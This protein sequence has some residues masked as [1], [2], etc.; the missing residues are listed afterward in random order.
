MD[1]LLNDFSPGLFIMQTIIF[2]VLLFLLGKFAWKPI[3]HSLKIR[4]ESIQD[5]LDAA[6][7]AKEEM[8]KLKADNEKLLDEAR[9]QRDIILQE[10]RE[11]ATGIKDAA[12]GEASKE[13]D[14]IVADA[15]E[16]IIIEK[17][18]AM[19]EVRTLVAELSLEVAEK[20]LKKNLADEGS[21]KE[22]ISNYINE[23]KLN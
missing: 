21:Q 16:A 5:A 9:Q 15:R 6:E 23:V 10:A 4:E 1:Q 14:K 8:A 13:A 20:L 11:V 19:A 18:A 7:R 17:Q 22:L 3:I 2:L 12:K